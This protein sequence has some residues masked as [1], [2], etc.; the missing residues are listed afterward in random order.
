MWLINFNYILE[1]DILRN[2]TQKYL[3]VLVGDF[4]GFRGPNDAQT[5]GS[6]RLWFLEVLAG[7]R[8]RGV[9]YMSFGQAVS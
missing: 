5:P 4:L 7:T 9:L 3:G 6:L 2:H 1:I 8:P